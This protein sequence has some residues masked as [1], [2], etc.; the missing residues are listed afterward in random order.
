MLKTS[1]SGKVK[2]ISINRPEVKNAVDPD[3]MFAIRDEVLVTEKS[4]IRVIVL[5][6]EDG[7]F[8]SGAD[9]KSAIK[10]GMS[11]DMAVEILKNCYGPTIKSIRESSCIIIAAVNGAAAGIGLD[12]ALACDLRVCSENAVFSELFIKVGLI[13]D[14]GGTWSLQRIIG[15]ARAKEMTFTGMPIDAHKAL[16]WGL[17]NR[18]YPTD[19]FL[20]EVFSFASQISNQSSDALYYGKKAIHAAQNST[21]EESLQREAE[22]Q[23]KIF[24][25]K[26][27]FEGFKAF[28][29]KRAPK[30]IDN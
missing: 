5:T 28:V 2:Y 22:F 15:E 11:A 10:E 1:V 17:V 9:I 3:T 21:F 20:N 29:E 30:W 24:S 27:G 18:I 4:D 6:G 16:N 19:E 25:G 26:W 23:H 14:G 13:P 12:L 7:A 8:C